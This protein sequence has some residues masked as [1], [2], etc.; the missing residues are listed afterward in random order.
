MDNYLI[1]SCIFGETFH[2]VYPAPSNNC[3]FFTNNN[4]LK[5]VII[6][7]GWVYVFVDFPISD[8]KQ[9][10]IQS[11][12][13]KFLVFLKDYPEFSKFNKIIYYDH[14]INMTYYWLTRAIEL[15]RNNQNYSV[16]I[17]KTPKIKR[18]I[19][20][21]V[22][23]AMGQPR[24]SDSMDKTKI[25]I[26]DTIRNNQDISENIR[27]CR[28]GLLIYNNYENIKPM[29]EKIYKSCIDLNQPECQIFWGLFSQQYS[30]K[31][32]M[33]ENKSLNPDWVCP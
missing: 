33:I 22:K 12:Y 13:I 8:F 11:K 3:F 1:I 4:K 5:Q 2:N 14:K 29:L 20:D 31:I 17:R 32:L 27:I 10:S 23:A 15:S 28:T 7:K 16:I 30:N 19:W 26:N 21:E 25:F 6:D 18:K 24:Y 9:S